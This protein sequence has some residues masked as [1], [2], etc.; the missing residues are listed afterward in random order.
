MWEEGTVLDQGSEGACVGFAWVAD[1]LAEPVAPTEQPDEE[2]GA[3]FASKYYRQAQKID[4]WPGEDY[5]GTS[6]LA[7]AKVMQKEGFISGYSWC[8]SME[9]I[10][11]TILTTGPVVIGIPWLQGMYDTGEDG[12]VKVHGNEVGGHALTITGY[13]PAME[14]DGVKQE[15]FRWRNS[16]GKDYGLDGS[17]YIRYND[18]A[19]LLKQTG[20]ACVPLGRTVPQFRKTK[21]KISIWQKLCK[22]ICK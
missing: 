22:I 5:E 16:W 3:S 7:G 10:R 2:T 6:V 19:A 15:V 4:Q 8:F 14:I 12:V 21:T 11:D 1:L 17:G 18:L 20:E 9:D 13:D